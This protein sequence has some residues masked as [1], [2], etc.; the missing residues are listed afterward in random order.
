LDDDDTHLRES[1]MWAEAYLSERLGKPVEVRAYTALDEAELGVF[2]SVDHLAFKEE[3][4]YSREEIAS[5]SWLRGFIAFTVHVEGELAGMLY[6][7]EL[8][9]STFFL[10]E[11]VSLREGRGVGGSLVKLL[12]QHCRERSYSEIR[13]YTE[14]VDEKGRKL[15]HFY[16]G[17]GFRLCGSAPEKGIEMCI[18]ME[19]LHA[20]T[21]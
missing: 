13:L 12:I 1:L 16:E 15:R 21:D 8:D 3:L 7:Y 17:L 14:E 11:V 9:P 19:G 2:E 18:S 5:K 20:C 6:G 10:D 4:W